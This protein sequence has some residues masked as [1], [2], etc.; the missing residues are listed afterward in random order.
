MKLYYSDASPYARKVR[1][2]A[3]EKNIPLELIPTVASDDPPAL[4]KANAI[5]KVPT[6]ELD[7][8]SALGESGHICTY[9]ESLVKKP[10]VFSTKPVIL[11]RDALAIGMMDALIR[12]V[13]EVRRP[14]DKQFQPWLDR[15]HRAITRTLDVL[16]KEKF[17]KAFTIDQITLITALGYLDL[18]LPNFGWRKT[19][20]RLARWAEKLAGRP[21][22][23][24]TIPQS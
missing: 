24:E 20:K 1:I 12:H 23:K 22:V 4:H 13:L 21:S 18:R 7:D 2:V 16:E 5:G 17:G 15:Q 19:H 8:G 3:M 6:L 10:K 9:L 11:R 14:E